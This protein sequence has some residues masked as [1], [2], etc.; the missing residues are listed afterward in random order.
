M[1]TAR[2]PDM[3]APTTKTRFRVEGMDCAG[4]ALKVETAARRFGGV[5]DVTVSVTAASMTV[6]HAGDA[7]LDGLAATI[8]RLG[9]PV[10]PVAARPAATRPAAPA[11]EGCCA[12]HD[13]GHDHHHGAGND[14]GHRHAHDHDHDHDHGGRHEN[15]APRQAHSH[16]HHTPS[17]PR[18]LSPPASTATTTAPRTA[19]GGRRPRRG[20]RSPAV[21]PSRSPTPSATSPRRS[22]RGRSWRRLRSDWCRSRGGRSSPPATAHP[23]RSRC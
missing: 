14:H 17:P 7:D 4:C 20:W 22:D 16:T 23:S 19:R 21:P 10:M 6:T 5:E 18:P 12:G 2:T 9:Y 15:H 1:R 8:T 3:T 13:H 11:A